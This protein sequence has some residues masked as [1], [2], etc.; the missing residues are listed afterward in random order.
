[1]TKT[2]K[3][4]II[5]ISYNAEKYI[6][7][8]IESVVAQT[9]P[10]IEYIIIDG[11]SKD[12]TTDIIKQYKEHITFWISEPDKSHFDA[13][14]KG[15]EKATG[16][17]V[18][19][20]NAGDCIHKENSLTEMMEGADDADLIYSRAEYIDEKGNR[21]AWHKK[22][23]PPA[24]INARSFLNGMVVCHHCMIVKRTIAPRY[25]LEPWKVS[26]DI[27][28]SIRV[29]KNVKSTHFWDDIFCL[30]LEGGISA[31]NR[32]DAIKERFNISVVHYGW[33][34]AI[35]EQIKISFQIIRRGK[36]S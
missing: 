6:K 35:L 20:M 25:R 17:Y 31:N 32:L 13:M 36:I 4:S 33:G 19:F 1:M 34:A 10:N 30:Y 22:T 27:D 9:Y 2:P 7:R 5:T 28:W 8:T 24:K 29:M 23:P 21:R 26:N 16:D 12:K 15:L 14:N 11:A 3:V 18:L